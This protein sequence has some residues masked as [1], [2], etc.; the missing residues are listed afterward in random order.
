MSLAYTINETTVTCVIDGKIHTIQRD[1]PQVGQILR[2]INEQADEQTV[3]QLFN[4]LQ[5]VKRY[6]DEHVEVRGNSVYFQDQEIHNTVADR[7][8]AFMS[9]DLPYTPL[10]EFLKR[11]MNNPSHRAV[12]ELYEF[13]EHEGLPITTDGTFLAYKGVRDDYYSSTGNKSTHVLKGTVDEGGHI[14]NGIGEE[15]IVARKDVDDNR[16]CTCSQGLHAGAYSYASTWS[17]RTILVEIDPADVVSVPSD[18]NGRKIRICRYKVIAKCEGLM[19]ETLAD[20]HQPYTS[21]SEVASNLYDLD[22]PDPL[23]QADTAYDV[24][25]ANGFEAA[26]VAISEQLT[27]VVPD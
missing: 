22:D 8:L 19:A 21:P 27:D 7:I 5:A 9:D 4:R 3:L 20:A 10:V 14:Y 12:N 25:Y 1:H 18:A 24:G 2:L 23:D 16:D 26:K 17:R 6:L 11:L 13:L 15:I